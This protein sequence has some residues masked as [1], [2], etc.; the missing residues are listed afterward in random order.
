LKQAFL[1]NKKIIFTDKLKKNNKAF[2]EAFP[3]MVISL[4]S[5]ETKLN[6]TPFY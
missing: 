4:D 3:D 1:C 2:K 6:K 5:L